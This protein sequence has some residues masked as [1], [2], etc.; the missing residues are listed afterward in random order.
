[1]KTRNSIIVAAVFAISTGTS[2]AHPLPKSATPKPNAALATSPVE[3][4]IGFSEG[5]VLAFSG[6]ELDDQNGKPVLI[7]DASLSPTDGIDKLS[8]QGRGEPRPAARSGRGRRRD[9]SAIGF[10]SEETKCGSADQVSLSVEGVVNG[11]VGGK[12]SLG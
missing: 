5:L 4:R 10:G 8:G 12:K 7:G 9:P 11:G 6:I 2:L 3:I 1:M